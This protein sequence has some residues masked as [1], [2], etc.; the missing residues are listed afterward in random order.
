MRDHRAEKQVVLA[1]KKAEVGCSL[2]TTNSADQSRGGVSAQLFPVTCPDPVSEKALRRLQASPDMV[3]S[4][5]D[6]AVPCMSSDQWSFGLGRRNRLIK[7][8]EQEG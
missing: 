7:M 2:G 5:S 4:R 6:M 3:G 1:K 8:A